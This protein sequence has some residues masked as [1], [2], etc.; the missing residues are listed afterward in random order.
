MK[1][2]ELSHLT[3]TQAKGAKWAAGRLKYGPE[4]HGEEPLYEAL[5]E[6]TDLCVYLDEAERRGERVADLR[7]DAEILWRRI[8]MRIRAGEPAPKDAA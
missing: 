8:K 5:A 1:G 6:A 7:S 3:L 2:S 4:W